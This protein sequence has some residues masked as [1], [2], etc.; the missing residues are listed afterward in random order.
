MT[1]APEVLYKV[2]WTS[3]TGEARSALATLKAASEIAAA[4]GTAGRTNVRVAVT[5]AAQGRHAAPEPPVDEPLVGE[6]ARRVGAHLRTRTGH[7]P[8][9]AAAD[10]GRESYTFTEGDVVHWRDGLDAS[11]RSA[12][13]RLARL[14]FPSKADREE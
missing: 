9:D 13:G 5:R 10:E 6:A 14:A 8:T 12:M 4:L 7:G 2:T 3:S 1:K 11:D